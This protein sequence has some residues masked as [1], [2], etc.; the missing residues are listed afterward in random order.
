MSWAMLGDI[1][2][3]LLV[4]AARPQTDGR[5]QAHPELESEGGRRDEGAAVIDR[6][7]SDV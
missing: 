4:R 2:N 7:H 6:G 5:R 3:E 1:S